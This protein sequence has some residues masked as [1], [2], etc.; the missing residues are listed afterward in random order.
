TGSPGNDVASGGP[1]PDVVELGDGNDTFVWSPGDGSDAIEGGD[2]LD[3][4]AFNGSN[5]AENVTLE[6]RGSRLLLSR[7]IAAVLLD[8]AGIEETQL[9]LLGGADTLTVRDTTA[10]GLVRVATDLRGSATTA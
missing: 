2:G 5:A 6:A 7:D 3:A 8:A 9:A 4:L 1:G 10:A